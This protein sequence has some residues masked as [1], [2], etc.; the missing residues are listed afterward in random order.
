[1]T[2]ARMFLFNI[3]DGHKEVHAH[4]RILA[5]QETPRTRILKEPR[6]LAHR[7]LYMYTDVPSASCNTRA[8][9]QNFCVSPAI[10]EDR[11]AD[12]DMTSPRYSSINSLGR[13]SCGI[14]FRR[15]QRHFSQQK[16]GD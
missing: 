10:R 2:V 6:A 11:M 15:W 16:K 4:A 12:N 7:T 1:M 9:L 8:P 3:P 13:E 5:F 14:T